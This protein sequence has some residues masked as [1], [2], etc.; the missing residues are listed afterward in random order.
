MG[1]E[2]WAKLAALGV[3]CAVGVSLLVDWWRAHFGQR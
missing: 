1:W 2:D 3:V